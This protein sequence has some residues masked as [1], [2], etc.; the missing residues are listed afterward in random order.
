MIV[1]SFTT[2]CPSQIVPELMCISGDVLA[3]YNH[4]P[5]A[6]TDNCHVEA[7]GHLLWWCSGQI[8]LR[9]NLTFAVDMSQWLNKCL[10]SFLLWCGNRSLLNKGRPSSTSEIS[11][12]MPPSLSLSQSTRL[13]KKLL[14]RK[15]PSHSLL[16]QIRK[17]SPYVLAFSP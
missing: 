1:K 2:C 6:S 4:Q 14:Q 9:F 16:T 13:T 11:L 7:L 15:I 10:L 8:T 12:L 17:W 3:I 5:D